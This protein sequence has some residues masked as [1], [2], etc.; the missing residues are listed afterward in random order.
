M[1]KIKITFVPKLASE[2]QKY[3]TRDG[4]NTA[5]EIRVEKHLLYYT[6]ISFPIFLPSH[7]INNFNYMV[8][9]TSLRRLYITIRN[10]PGY[11][12]LIH[13]LQ[14]L[15]QYPSRQQQR[16][17]C[18]AVNAEITVSLS[19]LGM[20]KVRLYRKKVLVI[21][22]NT[23]QLRWESTSIYSWLYFSFSSCKSWNFA[24]MVTATS[25][26]GFV[27]LSKS[28]VLHKCFF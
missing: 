5:I 15:L 27:K 18:N 1:H 6:V 20:I 25:G 22:D 23:I 8:F 16:K 21:D 14:S 19:Q 24:C 13:F 26:T 28:C 11:T 4:S 7:T 12:C 17:P 3:S 9:T 2:L 10:W